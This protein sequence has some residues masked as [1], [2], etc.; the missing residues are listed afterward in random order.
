MSS[1]LWWGRSNLDYSRNRVVI[2]L[3]SDLGWK[4]DFFHPVASQIGLFEAYLHRL[5]KPDIIWV[6]CF[7]QRDILSASYWANKWGVPL[8]VDPLISAYEKEVFE[9]NKWLPNSKRAKKKRFWEANLFSK[10]DIIIAD[11]PVHADYFKE[12]LCVKPDKLC[13]LYVGA[14][15][16]LF[17][18]MPPPLSQPPFEVLF[19]G[20][21]LKLQGVDVIVK[22]A[23]KNQDLDIKWVLLGDGDLRTDI[24]KEARGLNNI[25]F[26]PWIKYDELPIRIA[27]AHVLLGIFGTTLK[28]DLV[29]PNKVFQAMAAGRPLITRRSKAYPLSLGKS[30]VIGW[31]PEGDPVSLAALVRK[32]IKEPCK[33]A[34][35]G[36]ETRKLF[37]VFFSEEKLREMLKNILEKALYRKDF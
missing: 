13:V 3:F 22:A 27:K 32:W 9:R 16:D 20:S 2:G 35:R 6:S 19:Y 34:L 33:L 14:E 8:I 15:T 18:P 30:N 25:F 4:V 7:R 23:Q 24:E 28:S 26:E 10:A 1:V 29:I 36:K 17:V 5:N 31:V 37:D 12:E 21:F 11:T